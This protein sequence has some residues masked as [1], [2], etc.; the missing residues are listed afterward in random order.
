[1]RFSVAERD[2][3]LASVA[4][5][6]PLDLAQMEHL[7]QGLLP[8]FNTWL[9]ESTCMTEFKPMITRLRQDIERGVFSK[10]PTTNE[11]AA[12][13]DHMGVVLPEPLV[14]ELK[15]VA[16]APHPQPA[17][18][19]TTAIVIPAWVP[20]SLFGCKPTRPKKISRGRPPTAQANYGVLIREGQRI[21]MEAARTGQRMTLPEVARALQGIPCGQGLSTDNIERRLKGKLPIDQARATAGKHA[22]KSRVQ[23]S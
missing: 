6:G 1:M 5:W 17:P 8:P 15:D 20:N 12:W 23:P 18:Q 2:R 21:L 9:T 7:I 19:S 3:H 22:L 11:F 16:M 14:Q 13:C 4:H 10:A